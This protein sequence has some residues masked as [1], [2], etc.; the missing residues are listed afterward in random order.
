M[1]Q[2]GDVDEILMHPFFADLDTGKLLNKQI[3]APFVPSISNM[4]DLRH[5]DQEILSSAL[6][7]SHVP[8]QSAAEI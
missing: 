4:Q 2:N 5:F 8:A 1:G 7:E 6:A 3:E